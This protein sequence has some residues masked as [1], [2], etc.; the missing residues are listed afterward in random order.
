[1]SVDKS[2]PATVDAGD[3][4]NYSIDWTLSGNERSD[5]LSI[6]D[7]LPDD[8]SFVSATGG[9]VHSGEP[10]GGTVTWDLGERTPADGDTFGISVDVASPLPDGAILTNQVDISDDN[11]GTSDSDTTQT[12]VNSNH[13]LDVIKSGP[14]SVNAGDQIFYTI[15]WSISG[16][17]DA[18]DVI[19]EDVV[20]ENAAFFS[21]SGASSID[22]PGV[23]NR[24]L[25]RWHLG[26]QAHDASGSVQLVVV[27]DNPLDDGTVIVNTASIADGNGGTSDEDDWSTTVNSSHGFVLT[28]S[29]LPDPIAPNGIINYTIHWEVTGNEPAHSVVITDYIPANTTYQGCGGCIPQPTYARWNLGDRNPGDQGDLSL[30]VRVITPLADETVITNDAFIADSNGGTPANAQATTLVDSDHYLT[31]EKSAPSAV[32]AG[33]EIVYTIQYGVYGD[34]P[35][36]S[37][38]ITDA[39]PSNTDNYGC[40]GGLSCQILG[41]V[42]TWQLGTLNPGQ[43]GSVE[44]TVDALDVLPDGTHI[45]NDAYIFDADDG[46][47]QDSTDTTVTSGHGFSISKE[48][49]PDPVNAGDTLTY[50]ITW[51]VGGSEQAQGVYVT[52]TLPAEVT[53]LTA[54]DGGDETSPGSGVVVWDL[55][56]PYNPNNG[57]YVI[58]VTVQV[59]DPLPN[60]TVLENEVVIGDSN[61]GLPASASQQTTVRSSHTLDVDKDGPTNTSPDALIVYTIDWSVDGNEATD[62]LVIEDNTPDNSTFFNAEG[63][64]TI[65]DPGVGNSGLV[66]WRLG[67]QLPG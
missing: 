26:D 36:P 55:G 45:Y 43:S 22:D 4:L 34:E 6:V 32:G 2:A 12:T 65:D 5:N 25:V 21:A 13:V 19:I 16:T 58:V 24:G 33:D 44:L 57:D 29:D 7:T 23:G 41:N 9:G 49:E 39:I 54:S 51:S 1:M 46:H 52:D 62:N 3:T 37:V 61:G 8:V 50:T 15:N 20:P 53:F 67:A 28:K 38:V 27:A 42:A 18:E 56:G 17:E 48:D 66:R 60:D 10:S 11:G 35:A 31:L 64:V 47:D 14:A 63:A 40:S 30:Q 59:D